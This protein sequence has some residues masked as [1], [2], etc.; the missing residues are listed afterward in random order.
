MN[1]QVNLM[2]SAWNLLDDGDFDGAR[3][4]ASTA[5]ADEETRGSGLLILA[6]CDREEGEIKGA[7]THLH[8]ACET[9]AEW[10]TPVLWMAEI[11]ASEEGRAE[12]ALVLATR[13]VQLAD[14][15]EVFVDALALKAGL[16]IGTGDIDAAR[17]T[18]EDA[19]EP[20]DADVLPSL[21][22]EVAHLFLAVGDVSTAR[23][24]FEAIVADNPLDADG[25]HGVGFAA[26]EVGDTPT[27]DRAWT[28]TL[29]LDVTQDDEAGFDPLSEE[30]VMTVT[31]TAMEKLPVKAR[32]ALA[33]VS[34]RCVSHPTQ[35]EVLEGVDPRQLLRVAKNNG[36]VSELVL[37]RKNIEREADDPVSLL[38]E[39]TESLLSEAEEAFGWSLSAPVGSA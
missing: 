22:L 38:H 11:L 1:Q 28:K 25:W 29:E 8:A 30:D 23:E 3:A 24:H 27:R 14:D 20:G 21:S 17:K 35:H 15:E 18:L 31:E 13:A 6:A 5:L 10:V 12:E 39:V 2:E 7:L 16:E 36:T 37:Y 4:L 32:N 26:R 33:D 34:K 19:P 9:D